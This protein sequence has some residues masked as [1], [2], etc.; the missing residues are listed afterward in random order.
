MNHGHSSSL[1]AASL[2]AGLALL[3]PG[4]AARAGVWEV[5]IQDFSFDPPLLQIVEGDSVHWKNFDGVTHTVTSG[6]NCQPNGLFDSG[7]LPAGAEFGWRFSEIGIY[8]YFCIP[9]CAGG[10]TGQVEVLAN[11]P[12]QQTTWGRI[13]S[14]YR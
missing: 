7:N 9:H 11:T 10:M 2:L 6:T 4:P 8:P 14:L 3:L 12:A 13:R 1:R 5:A